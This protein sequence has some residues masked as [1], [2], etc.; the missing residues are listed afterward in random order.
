MALLSTQECAELT[1]LSKRTI[2]N[3]VKSGK[4]SA[5]K[6]KKGFYRIDISELSRV[7]D[8]VTLDANTESNSDNKDAVLAFEYEAKYLKLENELLKDQLKE[9][10]ER[11]LKLL[12]TVQNTTKLLEYKK[13]K[14]FLFL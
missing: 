6:D 9:Y 11:E 8:S 13:K 12:E 1:K 3:D 4:L 5:S 10:K 2:Q 14:R 7:Y